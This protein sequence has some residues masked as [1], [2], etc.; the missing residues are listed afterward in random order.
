M[1]PHQANF[2]FS[3][4]M[5]FHQVG[6]AGLK[7]LT[8]G[9]SPPLACR[10]AG[11]TGTS[12]HAWL[13]LLYV[14]FCCFC[15]ISVTKIFISPILRWSFAR[16]PGWSAMAPSQLTTTSTSQVTV[17]LLPSNWDKRHAP[18]CRENFCTF[19]KDGASPGLPGWS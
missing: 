11:I 7:L 10:S 12:H 6:Q 4:E 1:P 15:R 8:S 17:I 5:R 18:P 16:F 2:F 13:L 9:G 3:V 19:S 14:F